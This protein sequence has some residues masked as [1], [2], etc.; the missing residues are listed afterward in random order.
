MLGQD[1]ISFFYSL[2]VSQ[3]FAAF[4]RGIEKEMILQEDRDGTGDYAWM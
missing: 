1:V 2:P 3:E 4:V